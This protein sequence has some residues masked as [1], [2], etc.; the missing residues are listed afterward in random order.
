MKIIAVEIRGDAKIVLTQGQNVGDWGDYAAYIGTTHQ[1][2]LYVAS[3]GTKLSKK[4]AM[5]FFS[6]RYLKS[7]EELRA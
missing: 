7:E 4:E 5:A 3:S 6:P 1:A 2:D